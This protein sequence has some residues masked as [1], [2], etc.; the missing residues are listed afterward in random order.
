MTRGTCLCGT[1]TW[2]ATGDLTPLSHCHCAMCRKAHAAPF[3]SFTSC[4]ADDFE[5]TSGADAVRFFESSPGVARAFCST[6]GSSLPDASP[7]NDRISLPAGGI[8]E[9]PG[10]RGGRHIF[11]ASKA[12]WHQ[13]DDGAECHDAW[14]DGPDGPSILPVID[15]PDPGPVPDGI[16]RGSCLCGQIRFEVSE[17]FRVVHNCHCSLCRRARAAAHTTNG[18][19]SYDGV[20]FVSGEALLTTYTVP[21]R[22]FG[23]AFCST[24]GSG[25]PRR[26]VAR[27]ITN[28][29]LGVLD[30]TPDH[31]PDDH[32]FVGS[33]AAWYEITDDLPQFENGPA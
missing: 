14:P 6:C 19:V 27:G 24:C 18:F 4:A 13:I 32:I 17:S 8:M 7:G 25:M 23:Q 2:R 5:W 21:G 20:R 30:D 12:P 1:V 3:V 9:D 15:R 28:V 11:V 33:K 31:G 10:L 29:P 22:G 26:N 16:V